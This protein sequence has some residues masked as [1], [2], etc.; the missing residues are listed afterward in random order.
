MRQTVGYQ[1]FDTAAELSRLQQLYATL[2]LYTNFFQP[3]IKLKSKERVGSRV[4]KSYHAPQTPYQRVLACADIAV[5]D[6]KKLQRQYQRLNP[7]ALKR[8]LDKLRQ[9]L[10][11]LAA[12]KR[13][14]KPKRHPN[15]KSLQIKPHLWA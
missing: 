11:R 8:E 13:P 6:K 3:M 9:E 14:P 1:R 12:R 7:A 4:K 15:Q 2:R 10:F 5:A